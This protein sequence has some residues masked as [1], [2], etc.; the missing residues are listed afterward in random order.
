MDDVPSPNRND[1]PNSTLNHSSKSIPVAPA[2][3]NKNSLQ[4]TNES[5]GD[6]IGQVEQV[7][8]NE[9]RNLSMSISKFNFLQFSQWV[10][11]PASQ[12]CL[13]KCRIT[14][15]RKGM[16]RGLFPLYYLHLERDYGKKVFLLAGK[17][18]CFR[19]RLGA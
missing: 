4:N 12:G 11:Q 5:E 15:D 6:V 7:R 2:D 17:Y 16:D 3:K 1:I 13:Y 18:E 19:R 8:K 9:R 14:R 10:V